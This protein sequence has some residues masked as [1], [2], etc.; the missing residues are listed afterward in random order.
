LSC[1]FFIITTAHGMVDP[2]QIISPYDMH[3]NKYPTEV[4]ANWQTTIPAMVAP[5]DTS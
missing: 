2:T 1:D 3:I 4:E 5:E